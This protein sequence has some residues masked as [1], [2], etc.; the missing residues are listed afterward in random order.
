MICSICFGHCYVHHQ[1]LTTVVL[2][3]T[4][5]VPS[6]V[7]VGWKLSAGRLDKCPGCRLFTTTITTMRGPTHT[8]AVKMYLPNLQSGYILLRNLLKIQ[9]LKRSRVNAVC[10]DKGRTWGGEFSEHKI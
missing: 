5:A 7:V 2:I 9:E 8:E 4:W 6:W 3:T 1:E 10:L